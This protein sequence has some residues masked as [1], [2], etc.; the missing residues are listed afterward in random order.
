[1]GKSGVGGNKWPPTPGKKKNKE[2]DLTQDLGLKKRGI[3]Q[4]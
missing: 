3:G 1:L 4:G 2:R